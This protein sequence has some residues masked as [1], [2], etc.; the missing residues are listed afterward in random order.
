M[1]AIAACALPGI[2]ASA[3]GARSSL[4]EGGAGTGGSAGTNGSAGSGAS[5]GS[6]VCTPGE[7]EACYSGPAGTEGVGICKAGT[8]SC[9]ADGSGFGPCA[10]EVLPQAEN[11]ATPADESCDG[12]LGP[13]PTAWSRGTGDAS[14]DRVSAIAT[15]ATSVIVVGTFQGQLDF[16]GGPL[17]P[18]SGPKGDNVFVV[19]FGLDGGVLWQKA[20]GST[21]SQGAYGHGLAVDASG[22]LLVAGGFTGNMSLGGTMLSA[23]AKNQDGFVAKLDPQGNPLW[24][25]RFGHDG[26]DYLNYLAD[27]VAMDANGNVVVVGYGMGPVDFGAGSVPC[28]KKTSNA[29]VAKYTSE[30]VLSFGN[31]ISGGGSAMSAATTPAGD[32]FLSG[33]IDGSL[34]FGGTVLKGKTDGFVARL[35]SSG[36]PLWAKSFGD[37]DAAH[38]QR[39]YHV[40]VD[41]N[42]DLLMTGYFEN[43]IDLGGGPLDAPGK[44]NVFVAK[45]SGAGQHLW[46]KAYGPGPTFQAEGVGLAV[47]PGGNALVAGYFEDGI[48]LG[49]GPI[50][51]KA[52]R[53]AFLLELGPTGD[54]VS[55]KAFGITGSQ[56]ASSCAFDMAGGRLVG[57]LYHEQIDFGQGPL[58][59]GAQEAGSAFIARLVP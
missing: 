55:S 28:S 52:L 37:N 6:G 1:I 16:G 58:P 13:C 23:S 49:G 21:G 51:P 7:M 48:D 30:G 36:N 32:I 45:L 43:G 19:K 44:R 5:T 2:I 35:D 47:D 42:G 33:E 10:G 59:I 14:V 40:A 15:D 39:V 12:S 53:S 46:S 54:Y 20:F 56:V 38:E 31:C 24:S 18:V 22:N 25:R 3:C 17:L 8:R 34:A 41:P 11:C 9:N 57:G 29:I 27:A 4:V 50:T 26:S